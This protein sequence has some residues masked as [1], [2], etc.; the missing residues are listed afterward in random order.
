MLNY[1]FVGD[2][3][4]FFERIV[5]HDFYEETDNIDNLFLG[6][7]HVYCNIDPSLLDELN[8]QNNFNLSTGSQ[9]FMGSYYAL[10]EAVKRHNISYVYLEMYYDV[11]TG[12]EGVFKDPANL[13]RSWY[14]TDNMKPSLNKL[15]YMLTAFEKENYLETFLPF[16]RCREKLFD[17]GYIDARLRHKKEQNYLEFTCLRTGENN[18]ITEYRDKGYSYSTEN[19]ETQDLCWAKNKVLN[20]SPLTEDAKLYLEKI[21]EFCLENKIEIILFSSPIYELQL[22]SV[23][24]YDDYVTEINEIAD[25]YD[26]PYLDFNLCKEEDFPIQNTDN[27]RDIGHLNH[28][29][30]QMFTKYFWKTIDKKDKSSFCKS[31]KEKLN[32]SKRKVY[33]LIYL[34]DGKKRKY[35]IATNRESEMEYQVKFSPESNIPAIIIKDYSKEKVFE[36]ESND[37]GIFEITVKLP[38]CQDVFQVLKIEY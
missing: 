33:G 9:N 14:N 20:R 26:V 22:I 2:D 5:W 13:Y 25:K 35:E 37:H 18:E 12:K 28:Q 1:M 8:G 30:A 6:S 27:F 16:I 4:N 38:E 7:S 21:I 34:D 32:S 17:I 19:I 31:Y 10:K 29:G 24:N 23:D 3:A 15:D 36:M 11:S